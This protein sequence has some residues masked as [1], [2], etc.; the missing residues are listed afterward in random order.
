MDNGTSPFE[1]PA[2]VI[3]SF[4]VYPPF[5][6]IT[7]SNPPTPPLLKSKTNE[8]KVMME[9]EGRKVLSRPRGGQGQRW[10]ESSALRSSEEIHA[11]SWILGS[12][13]PRRVK[14]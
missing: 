6:K 4:Y 8:I 9:K 12:E 5:F 14:L 13:P 11:F 2:V 1:S 10:T 3:A 7:T